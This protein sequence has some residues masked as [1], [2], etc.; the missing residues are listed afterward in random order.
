MSDNTLSRR[1]ALLAGC[2]LACGAWPAAAATESMLARPIPSSGEMLPVIG[3]G[4]YDVFD[5]DGSSAEIAD[6]RHIVDLLTDAGGRVIDTSPM[7]NRSER[8][9]GDIIVAGAARSDLFIATKVWTDGREAGLAQMR[10]SSELMRSDVI[11][12]M[13]VHNLRDTAVHMRSIRELQERGAI[14]YSGLTH[15][16][17]SAL[18]GLESAMKEY[19]P[20]FI[21]INYSLGEREAERRVLP[22]ARDMGIAVLINRP[23][24]AGA[25]FAP[26]AGRDLPPWSRPFAATW[27][28]F[29]LKF[30]VS[31]PAVSCVIPATSKPKHMADNAAAGLGPVPDAATRQRMADYI[32]GA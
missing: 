28:Q 29:F 24:Q 23:F 25:L 17:A 18:D 1:E 26:V 32:A 10:R 2:A 22:L 12:L 30:I 6:R 9:I 27:G 14:R 4:T 16:R 20:D 3:L 15:Y 8:I 5:V 7:Y 21:Q 19:R 31:H 11:D 13:Q